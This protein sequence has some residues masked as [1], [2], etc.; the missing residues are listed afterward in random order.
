[1]SAAELMHGPWTLAG[2]HFP[3]LVFSQRDETLNGV[4]DLITK[5]KQQSIPVIV[6]GAAE[7]L[8]TV[9][10][11]SVESVHPYLAPIAMIQSFYPLVTAISLG[12]GRN[13]DTPPRL[14][15]VTETV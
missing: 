13:P 11:P 2:N 8:T 1:M 9:T 14:Q 5:L 15:K 10:L 12:R 3:I 7:G 6:V 4:N